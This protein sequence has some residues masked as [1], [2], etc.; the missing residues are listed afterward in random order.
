LLYYHYHDNGK[1]KNKPLGCPRLRLIFFVLIITTKIRGDKKQKSAKA[2][3]T[4]GPF[5]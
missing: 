5:I 1:N 2:K 4:N 3:K